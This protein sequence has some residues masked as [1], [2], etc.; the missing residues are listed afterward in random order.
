MHMIDGP[1]CWAMCR[2]I[3]SPRAN[4][5]SSRSRIARY[6]RQELHQHQN[7]T[8]SCDARTPGWRRMPR[9]AGQRD[10][11]PGVGTWLIARPRRTPR[12]AEHDSC[13]P[14]EIAHGV[15]PSGTRPPSTAPRCYDPCPPSRRH[16]LKAISPAMP[17]QSLTSAEDRPRRCA[18]LF[19]SPQSR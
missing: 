9:A 10:V 15:S 3:A 11:A 6:A 4:S 16:G 8:R 18:T 12:P 14:G 17:R 1:G 13:R 5:R 19:G 7:R 2:R